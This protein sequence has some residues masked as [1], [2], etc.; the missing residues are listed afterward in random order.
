MFAGAEVIR[1]KVRVY[2]ESV[3]WVLEKQRQK[4]N[5]R[6]SGLETQD[7][8]Q[9]LQEAA[10][11]VV[12]SGNE[13]A[14]LIMLK[15]RFADDT[16]PVAELL[17]QAQTETEKTQDKALN[18]L[19]TAFYLKPGEGDRTGS[20]EFAHKSFGEFL[21]AERLK[22]AFQACTELDQRQRLRRSESE[23][24]R[25][26]YDLFG[27]GALT[28]GIVDYLKALIFSS[29]EFDGAEFDNAEFEDIVR[30]FQRLHQSYEN[31]SEGF[32]IDKMPSE[33]LPQSKMM[34]LK[35]AD[36]TTGLRQVD[37]Y[38]GLNVMIL[39]FELHRYGR[40]QADEQRWSLLHFHPCGKLD[41]ASGDHK[42]LLR[43]IGYSQ[44]I[45]LDTFREKVGH[46]FR[47]AD[48]SYANLRHAELSSTNLRYANLSYA[49]L[50]FAN[51]SYANLSYAV[52]SSVNLSYAKDLSY[53]DLENIRFNERT[54]WKGVEGLKTAK[55][56][57]VAL[58][59]RIGLT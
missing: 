43:I 7:L 39:L 44:L 47:H 8:R 38:A 40:Q 53:A 31:W 34:R 13:T 45:R 27:Y 2:D 25:Q 22:A 26:I 52:L 49:V 10:L 55:N 5:D 19:L 29:A 46:H 6:I 32:Y 21:F 3:R 18:N 58:K 35:K 15:R 23:V 54:N 51:L 30:L 9:V 4:L 1:A 37:I 41:D 24:A 14:K 48:L 20:V 56:V 11:C 28:V 36:I 42:K 16:N 50:D 12:Q 59:Q 17:K 57:P 33:N